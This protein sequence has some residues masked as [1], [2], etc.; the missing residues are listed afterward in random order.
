MTNTFVQNLNGR[1]AD[2]QC[3]YEYIFWQFMWVWNRKWFRGACCTLSYVWVAFSWPQDSLHYG[4][5][6]LTGP[7][8]RRPQHTMKWAHYILGPRPIPWNKDR[9]LIYRFRVSLG[10][11][12]ETFE[13]LRNPPPLENP[14]LDVHIVHCFSPHFQLVDFAP[15]DHISKKNPDWLSTM[16]TIITSYFRSSAPSSARI[17]SS[18]ICIHGDGT[19]W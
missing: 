10:G 16:H 5:D 4:V 17:R 15:C 8:Q 11:G 1:H 2:L 18:L 6:L 9:S 13:L 12:A 19:P 7:R 14:E 3:I